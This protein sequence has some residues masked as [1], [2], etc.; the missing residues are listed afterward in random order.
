MYSNI[1]CPHCGYERKGTWDDGEG[2]PF[3]DME[4]KC[5]KCDKWFSVTCDVEMY[6]NFYSRKE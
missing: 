6:F 2:G 1:E 5:N 3:E 4:Y